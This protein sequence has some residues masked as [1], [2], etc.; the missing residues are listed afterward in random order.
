MSLT[1]KLETIKLPKLDMPHFDGDIETWPNFRD[2]F[3]SSIDQ[4]NM[5]GRD[6]LKYLKSLCQG[7]AADV[8]NGFDDTN[9]SYKEAWAALEQIYGDTEAIIHS[10]LSALRQLSLISVDTPTLRSFFNNLDT[11][12]RR[13]KSLGIDLDGDLLLMNDLR[14]LISKTSSAL[15]LALDAE[16]EKKEGSPPF[17][18]ALFRDI[19]SDYILKREK[20]GCLASN[21]K[22]AA[23]G[24][25]D[26]SSCE[27]VLANPPLSEQWSEPVHSTAQGLAARS[28]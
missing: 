2:A 18:V 4:R 23:S 3:L 28:K 11:H 24:S 12:L 22:S 9:E 8:V 15:F 14:V 27:Q 6:K 1:R 5:A 20:L 17:T 25:S 16:R 21:G 13:L 26:N 7:A 10:H 19:L